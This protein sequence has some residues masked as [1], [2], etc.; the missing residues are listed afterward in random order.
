MR[1]LIAPD[2]VP[3]VAPDRAPVTSPDRVPGALSAAETAAAVAAGWAQAAPGD[4]TDRLPLSDGGPGFLDVLVDALGGDMSMVT[5][6]GPFGEPVPARVLVLG[7]TAYVEAAEAIGL[8]LVR[9]RAPDPLAA[10]SA[11][12]A[13]LLLAGQSTGCARVVVG[14]GGSATSDGGRGLVEALRGP[15]AGRATLTGTEVVAATATDAALMGPSGVAHGFAAG[16]GADRDTREVIED[17][18][19]AWA[20][21]TDGGLAVR[22]GAG[23][24][25]GVGFALLLLGATRVNGTELVTEA[26]DLEGRA[27]A[28]DLVVTAVGDLDWEM[29]RGRIPVGV[30][31]AA[32][33]AGR[34]TVVLAG[35]VQVGRR[36]LSANGIDA[37]YAWADGADH[38]NGAGEADDGAT[39]E[40]VARAA[41]RVARTWSH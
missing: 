41:H 36:E 17:R 16:K 34:P 10:S 32:Q 21:E 8:H 3:V 5:V 18:L 40:A 38:A 20:T 39:A 9:H 29:L 13:D 6:R 26:V 31:R 19:R 37:A 24:G 2:R 12:V 15:A 11:G 27:A 28:A 22:P 23:A 30:S 25:G 1:V 7:D 35:Q 14:V 4:V 33:R